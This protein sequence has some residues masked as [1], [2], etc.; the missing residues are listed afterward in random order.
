LKKNLVSFVKIALPISL[1]IYL[2]FHIYNQLTPSQQEALFLSF[3][4]ANYGWVV[5]S[6]FMGLLS[7]FIRGYRWSYQ[8]EAMGYKPRIMNNFLSVMIG[9]FVN[10]ALPRVGEVSRAAAMTKYEQIPFQKGFGT[11]LSERVVDLFVLMFIVVLTFV[12]QY[13]LL[14]STSGAL[15]DKIIEFG[16]SPLLIPAIVVLVILVVGGFLLLKKFRNHSLINKLIIILEGL[17]EGIRSIFKMEKRIPYLLAT[18]LIW[19]LYVGMF[20]ICFYALPETSHLGASAVFAAFILGSVAIVLIP[21]GIGAF[22]VGIMQSLILY[23]IA[24]ETGFALGWIIW[25]SQTA[26][27]L[28]FGGLSMLYIPIFNKTSLD[29]ASE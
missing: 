23:N 19:V 10:M 26:M 8:L 4:K 25:F 7:H 21:G 5:L 6:I 16:E 3:E 1:G 24:E 17:L 28:V 18:A 29:V 9:Y 14:K 20:W 2:V 13:E 22:P 12:L 11:I 15:I 27:I